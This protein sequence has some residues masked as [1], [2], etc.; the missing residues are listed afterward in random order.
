[1]LAKKGQFKM[2]SK[3]SWLVIVVMLLLSSAVWSDTVGDLN[4]AVPGDTTRAA[5]VNENFTAVKTAVDANDA[6]IAAL[7]ARIAALEATDP[8]PGPEGPSGPQGEPGSD[9]QV[10]HVFD[11]NGRDLGLLA[12]TGASRMWTSRAGGS[13]YGGRGQRGT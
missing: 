13:R 3:I 8:V 11:V 7:E 4:T 12:D 2:A 9:A 1:M 5:D 10:L 6:L